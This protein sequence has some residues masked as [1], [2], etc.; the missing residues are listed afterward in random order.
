MRILSFGEILWDVI[1]G[2]EHLGG[3]PL[4][5]AAHMAQCGNDAWMISRLGDDLLGKR[6]YDECQRLR[7]DMS[8]VEWDKDFPTGTV[9][10][11]LD[12]GQPDYTIHQN[13]AYDHIIGG[14]ALSLVSQSAFD[15][16]YFGSLGQR[17]SK[18]A[19]TLEN[20]L[21]AGK[22]QH[23]FYDVNLRKEGYTPA[24]ILKSLR[25]CS[26]VKLNVDE[27]AVVSRIALGHETSKEELFDKLIA[28]FPNIKVVIVTAA[29]KGCYVSEGNQLVHVPSTAVKVV[30]A[31]GAGDSFSAAFMHVFCLTGDV[32]HAAFVANRVGGFVASCPG[33]IPM[34]T[35]EIKAALGI[36]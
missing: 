13:V 28:K 29:D 11:K 32:L 1:D 19:M 22:F 15:I 36:D 7:V 31:V 18:S 8:L 34:Y 33:P 26:I 25:A 12:H 23:I 24:I 16:F 4:N 27:V 5:F 14:A 6:A 35:S 2:V 20:I 3:A 30:D 17:N 10:V 21:G 9:T